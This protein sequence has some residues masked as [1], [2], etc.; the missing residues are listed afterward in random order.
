M[1][2]STDRK[3][4]DSMCTDAAILFSTGHIQEASLRW[5]GV[6]SRLVPLVTADLANGAAEAEAPSA[7]GRLRGEFWVHPHRELPSSLSPLSSPLS[8]SSK[9]SSGDRTFAAYASAIRYVAHPRLARSLDDDLVLAATSVFNLGLCHHLQALLHGG[10]REASMCAKALRAYGAS[11]RILEGAGLCLLEDGEGE[12]Q[13]QPQE[14]QRG[15]ALLELALA[16]NIGHIYDQTHSHDGVLR[17]LE[18]LHGL[19]GSLDPRPGPCPCPAESESLSSSSWIEAW[20]ELYA[21]F[22]LTAALY[23]DSRGV[24]H[25]APCA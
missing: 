15:V 4:I 6:V 7:V 11:L 14:Q 19:L 13:H 18:V 10:D 21:P 2:N 5:H 23:P 9:M 25:P 8:S 16:N 22:L 3:E 24:C 20:S 17:Q 12:Q 1:A